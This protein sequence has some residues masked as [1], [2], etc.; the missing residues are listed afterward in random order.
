MRRLPPIARLFIASLSLALFT[1]AAPQANAQRMVSR[2]SNFAP[3]FRNG[4]YSRPSYHPLAFA[5]PFYSDYLSSVGYPVAAP[6]PMIFLQPPPPPVPDHPPAPVQP[7]LIE[8]RGDR[9][10]RV[11]GAESPGTEMIT[12]EIIAQIPDPTRS[13][14]RNPQPAP[15]STR[16]ATTPEPPPAILI[17]RD[18]RREETSDYTIANG[19]LYTHSDF[20]TNGAWTRKIELSSLDLSETIKLNQSRGVHFQLPSFPNEI[21]VRP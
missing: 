9:Y 14:A 15:A 21:I 8:L 5:D 18:G 10:V 13:E 2:T 4:A 12:P 7:L 11:S 1:A 16:P 20:Y 19:A 6:P 17:F 3:R